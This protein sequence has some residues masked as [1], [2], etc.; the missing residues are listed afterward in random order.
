MSR[1]KQLL[2]DHEQLWEMVNVP[3]ARSGLR[4]VVYVS[5]AQGQHG[6]RVKIGRPGEWVSMT[7]SNDPQLMNRLPKSII[8]D[9]I[10]QTRIWI[11]K[12]VDVLLKFWNQQI[13]D[14]VELINALVKY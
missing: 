3:Q 13:V 4:K 8:A 11:K 12:N 9:D 6:P 1:A 5:P 14:P 10:Y 2:E 7:I